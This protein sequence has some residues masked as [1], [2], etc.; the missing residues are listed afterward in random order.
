MITGKDFVFTGLQPWDIPIGSNA[1][2]IALEVSK[3][4][5]VLYVNTPLDKKTYRS[6]SEAPDIIHRQNTV[7]GKTH[8]LRQISNSLWVLDYPFTVLPINFLPDGKL[9]DLANKYNNTK[10]YTFVK[11][12][13]RQ[14]KF[15]DYILFID[16][17]IYR[18]FYAVKY[19]EPKISI[20]YRRD[21]MQPISFWKKHASRLEPLLESKSDIVLCNSLQLAQSA[22]KF[23]SY[24]YDVGQGVDLSGYQPDPTLKTPEDLVCIK[25]PIIGYAGSINSLR[26]DA[27]LIYRLA[28]THTNFSFVLVGACDGFFKSHKLNELRNVHFLGQKPQELVANYISHFDVCINPQLKNEITEGNYPRKIDEFLALGKP[29]IATATSTMNLFKEHIYLC[30]SADD[31]TEAL[32]KAMQEDNEEKRTERI[33]FAHSHSWENS[34]KSIYKHILLLE[35]QHEHIDH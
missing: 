29:V 5:R 13:L 18:S 4:N 30:S 3:H 2:D 19:L 11:K 33:R 23:N 8:C 34:V 28:C 32:T 20:Y 35:N 25:H 24:S 27:D 7:K 14:L 10:M 17:D 21:N 16:N 31:F 9:F 1:R 6:K 26:L 22:S 12:I 15:E